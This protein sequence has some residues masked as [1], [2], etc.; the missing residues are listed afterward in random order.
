MG[1]GFRAADAQPTP[2]GTGTQV[3]DGL[4]GVGVK[5]RFSNMVFLDTY[6]FANVVHNVVTARTPEL[7]ALD[8]FSGEAGV[9]RLLQSF[10]RKSQLHQFSA[11]VVDE[12]LIEEL[13]D[14]IVDRLFQ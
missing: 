4:R 11:D 7:G 14:L 12:M 10:P 3:A 2:A 13:D 8:G 1:I 6:Q 5:R 9:V